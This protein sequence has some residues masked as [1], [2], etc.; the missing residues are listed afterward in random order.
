MFLYHLGY[1]NIFLCDLFADVETYSYFCTR[2][3]SVRP[4]WQA[5]V[6]VMN[7]EH[8][9]RSVP[10]C[11]GKRQVLPLIRNTLRV[12]NYKNDQPK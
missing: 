4:K 3:L 6:M 12:L 11:A 9:E 8:P 2:I 1:K 10:H 5:D 7:K